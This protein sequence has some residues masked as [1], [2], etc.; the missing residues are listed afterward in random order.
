V[1]DPENSEFFD[2]FRTGN[3]GLTAERGSRVEGIGRPLVEPS[4]LPT[5]IDRMMP[6]SDAASNPC[7]AA[8]AADRPGPL[9]SGR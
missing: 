4:F 1:V 8:N 5:V 6:I 7:S 2:F 9:T 3:A